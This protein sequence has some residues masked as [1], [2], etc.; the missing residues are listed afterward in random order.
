M[1]ALFQIRDR[2]PYQV[3]Q[4]ISVLPLDPD[5]EDFADFYAVFGQPDKIVVVDHLVLIDSLALVSPWVFM[6]APNHLTLTRPRIVATDPN[7]PFAGTISTVSLIALKTHIAA[8]KYEIVRDL[9][10]GLR[11][12]VMAEAEPG[13]GG[14]E[15]QR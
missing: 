10:L 13:S 3:A 6:D 1:G 4:V 5:P 7:T 15:C 2:R 8:S 11:D 14:R 12:F 9:S